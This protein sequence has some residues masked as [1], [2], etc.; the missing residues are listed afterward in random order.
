MLRFLPQSN[1]RLISNTHTYCILHYAKELGGDG[2]RKHR[3][4]S[5]LTVKQCLKVLFQW[6]DFGQYLWAS[7]GRLSKTGDVTMMDV[8][9]FGKTFCGILTY[10]T[11]IHR[12]FENRDNMYK[13]LHPDD[14]LSEHKFRAMLQPLRPTKRSSDRKSLDSFLSKMTTLFGKIFLDEANGSYSTDDDKHKTRSTKSITEGFVRKRHSV[15]GGY[16]S[17]MHMC[18]SALSGFITGGVMNSIT[19]NDVKSLKEMYI[20]MTGSREEEL[21]L[22]GVQNDFDRGYKKE[23]FLIELD[24]WNGL[25]RGTYPRTPCLLSFPFTFG[26]PKD[27]RNIEESG[28]SMS[29][30]SERGTKGLKGYM[31][32]MAHRDFKGS[33]VLMS[34]NHKSFAYPVHRSFQEYRENQGAMTVH[35]EEDTIVGALFS[36]SDEFDS[37]YEEAPGSYSTNDDDDTN[38]ERE[39][40]VFQEEDLSP[41]LGS[42]ISTQTS[43]LGNDYAEYSDT[44]D[45]STASNILH[46]KTRLRRVGAVEAL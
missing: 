14:S 45:S 11:S 46:V 29:R 38:S 32:A 33:V 7:M 18:V 3:R 20:D 25:N 12:C 8:L 26:N 43:L 5:A 17:V 10:R 35:N 31:S 42:V 19:G 4:V 27:P 1:Y 13:M 16:G 22:K 37:D 2:S 21:N 6:E 39:L 44:S 24:E 28:P 36:S 9:K 23:A 15:G 34:T 30:F 41:T 40:R